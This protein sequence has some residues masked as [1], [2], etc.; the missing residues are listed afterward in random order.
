VVFQRMV[1]TEV[2]GKIV[3]SFFP[4]DSEVALMDTVS[5]PAKTHVDHFGAAL[6]HC[7]V[8][9]A[10][11]TRVVGLDWSGR[12]WPAYFDEHIAKDA[13]ILGIVEAIANFCFGGRSEHVAHN[14]ADDVDGTI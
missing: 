5:D 3:G 6:L 12:M 2:V 10:G 1:F 4:M 7:V 8:D 14:F 13:T 9:D 11:G